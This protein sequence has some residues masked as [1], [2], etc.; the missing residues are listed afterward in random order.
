MKRTKIGSRRALKHCDLPE[1]FDD[2]T[3]CGKINL[4]VYAMQYNLKCMRQSHHWHPDA[5]SLRCVRK[6]DTQN[7]GWKKRGT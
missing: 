6:L 1:N 2:G 7:S 3:R 4:N 5:A